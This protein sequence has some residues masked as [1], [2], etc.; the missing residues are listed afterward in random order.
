[1]TRFVV[2]APRKREQ[3][4]AMIMRIEIFLAFLIPLSA[5]AGLYVTFDDVDCHPGNPEGR[6]ENGGSGFQVAYFDGKK[7]ITGEASPDTG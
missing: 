3:H 7:S 4:E 6:C 1:M 2:V 5:D